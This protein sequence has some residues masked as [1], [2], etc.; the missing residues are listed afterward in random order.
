MKIKSLMLINQ[1]HAKNF[2]L[3]DRNFHTVTQPSSIKSSIEYFATD[4]PI[5]KKLL[6]EF[7]KIR[8]IIQ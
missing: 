2:D 8:K 7:M 3:L 4:F 1:K 6:M 5:I